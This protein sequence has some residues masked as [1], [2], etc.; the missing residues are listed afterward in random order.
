[1]IYWVKDITLNFAVRLKVFFNNILIIVVALI[2]A[3]EFPMK[4]K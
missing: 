1:M 4:E 2:K 3:K